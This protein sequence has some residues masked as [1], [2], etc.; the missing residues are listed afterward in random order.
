VCRRAGL[1]QLSALTKS[2]TGREPR[3][4][5]TCK[6][7]GDAAGAGTEQHSAEQRPGERADGCR[8]NTDDDCLSVHRRSSIGSPAPSIPDQWSAC[9][10]SWK[11]KAG[12]PGAAVGGAHKTCHTSRLGDLCVRRGGTQV[13]AGGTQS[14]PHKSARRLVCRAGVYGG[15][16]ML[17]LTGPR[18]T[19]SN[20]FS[21]C[22]AGP[23]AGTRVRVGGSACVEGARTGTHKS[24][25]RLVW[26]G[27]CAALAWIFAASPHPAM[28]DGDCLE[29]GH[30]SRR[31]DLCGTAGVDGGHVASGLIGARQSRSNSS[32][33]CR[34]GMCMGIRFRAGPSTS[35]RS[36]IATR[37]A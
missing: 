34:A 4:G 29:R 25:S 7:P 8:K 5:S 30:T 28:G 24:P 10:L 16:G 2:Q 18:R 12:I 36:T 32:T 9:R 6:P 23:G 37:Q 35:G 17:G 15:Y 33:A 27:W 31:A 22:R 13:V 19:R 26:H 3:N 21:A 1:V 14:V 11:H 20:S